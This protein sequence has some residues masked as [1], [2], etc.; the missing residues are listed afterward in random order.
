MSEEAPL[1][2]PTSRMLAA[3]A[4]VLLEQG[5]PYGTFS[6]WAKHAFTRAAEE[7]LLEEG[8]RATTSRIAVTTGLTRK[9]VARLRALD[10]PDGRRGARRYSRASRVVTAWQREEAFQDEWGAPAPLPF[11]GGGSTF[12]ELVRRFGRDVT[13]SALLEELRV[14]GAVEQDQEG[15]VTLL[16]RAFLPTR[17]DPAL[18][19]VLGR[20]VAGL[21]DTLA[22]N[23]AS[24]PADRHFQ[25]K[26]FY[27]NL[28]EEALPEVKRLTREH[29]QALLELLDRYMA[30]AD[31]DE[32][33]TAEGT[34]RRQ[35]GVG[36]YYFEGDPDPARA[37][38][39]ESE[40]D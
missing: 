4:S 35:A 19:D 16:T 33:P 27:D 30:S 17:H 34:G 1:Q 37:P 12:S 26:V 23:L 10:A 15:T 14:A 5:I 11:D 40:P 13:P 39:T 24:A 29:G 2:E 7:A 8:Q 20:D 6:E 22:H 28:P 31:R 32:N 3:L 9:E 25:R 38:S 21:L 18:M 36:I